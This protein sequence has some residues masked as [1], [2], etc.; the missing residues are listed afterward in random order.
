MW[1]SSASNVPLGGGGGV[2][3]AHSG[4]RDSAVRAPPKDGH[5]PPRPLRSRERGRELGD[6]PPSADQVCNTGIRR[7]GKSSLC[8]VLVAFLNLGDLRVN[9]RLASQAMKVRPHQ[10]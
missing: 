3:L 10:I 8:D 4:V 5:P 2:H 6:Q 1:A 9:G 7:K